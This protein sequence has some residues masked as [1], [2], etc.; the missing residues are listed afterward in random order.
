MPGEDEKDHVAVGMAPLVPGIPAS[1]LRNRCPGMF[2]VSGEAVTAG[3]S[4]DVMV[5]PRSRSAFGLVWADRSG[6]T[7]GAR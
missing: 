2:S 1:T 4:R 7:A 6:Q 3:Q 5:Q